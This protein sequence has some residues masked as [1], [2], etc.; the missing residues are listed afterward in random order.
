MSSSISIAGALSSSIR[1]ADG[2]CWRFVEAQHYVSTAK[3]TDTEAEQHRLET[4][5]EAT[6]PS[7]P[8]ECRELNFLLATPFRYGAPYPDGSRFRRAGLT[9]GVFYA[10]QREET[11]AAEMAYY[12]LL[13]FAESP[14]TAWPTNPGQFTA[15]GVEY[16]VSRCI[17]LTQPPLSDHRERWLDPIERA[18]CQELADQARGL[19]I[20]VIKYQSVRDP[21]HGLNIAILSCRAFTNGEPLAP[22][23]WRIHLSPSGVRAIREFPHS[24]LNFDRA[25]FAGDHRIAGMNWDRPARP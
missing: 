11:A 20:E 22:K 21:S 10:A 4:L 17:D 3:L 24:V 1:P 19:G 23:T 2:R 16:G 8:P 15:F 6:K 18:G 25:A 14:D 13:F 5:I 7:I 12:R 9:L